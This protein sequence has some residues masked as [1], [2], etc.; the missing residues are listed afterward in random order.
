MASVRIPTM[1]QKFICYNSCKLQRRDSSGFL[2]TAKMAVLNQ[3][4]TGLLVR[5]DAQSVC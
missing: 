5:V 3:P 1:A 2:Y 4:A